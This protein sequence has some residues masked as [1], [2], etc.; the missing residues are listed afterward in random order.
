MKF[1]KEQKEMLKLFDATANEQAIS[2]ADNIEY[3][4]RGL[5]AI[6]FFDFEH[7]KELERLKN[8]MLK[9]STELITLENI[10]KIKLTKEEAFIFALGRAIG[11][12]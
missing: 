11:K 12:V 10:L 6:S 7:R 1:D 5:R 3:M 8:E 4:Y 9:L 2:V